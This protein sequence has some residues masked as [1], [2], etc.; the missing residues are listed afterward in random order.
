MFTVMK[1]ADY[2]SEAETSGLENQP[3]VVVLQG[4]A[5]G[6]LIYVVCF[7]VMQR[8]G[9][10]THVRGVFNVLFVLIGFSLTLGFKILFGHKHASS[11]GHHCQHD[12]QSDVTERS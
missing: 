9:S 7:E 8:E 3:V 6:T 11:H 5:G 10:A 4:L 1:T 12:N 2:G